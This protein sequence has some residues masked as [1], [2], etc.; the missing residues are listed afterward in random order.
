MQGDNI[1]NGNSYSL[2]VVVEK[3]DRI[4][5][6][7]G[8]ASAANGGI[9]WETKIDYLQA[10]YF[11]QNGKQLSSAKELTSGGIVDCILYDLKTIEDDTRLYTAL[12]DAEGRMRAMSKVT[13][14]EIDEFEERQAIV[15][16]NLPENESFEGFSVKLFGITNIQGR[17]WPIEISEAICLN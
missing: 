1:G 2:D 15:S 11:M 8:A 12:Y 17:Y 3:G 5:F 13:E 9:A 16:L 14:V 10:A 4:Y 6:E 7:A